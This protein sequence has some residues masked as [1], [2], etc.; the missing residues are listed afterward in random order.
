MSEPTAPTFTPADRCANCG[1][2]VGPAWRYCEQCGQEPFGE[3][4]RQVRVVV[5]DVDMPISAMGRFIFK[6][7]IASI[8]TAIVVALVYYIL[9]SL[10]LPRG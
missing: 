6:W 8:P 9:W 7:T 10:I 3:I 1:A 5:T 4:T 2:K